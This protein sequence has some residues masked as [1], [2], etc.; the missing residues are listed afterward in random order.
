MFAA[1][2]LCVDGHEFGPVNGRWPWVMTL[3]VRVSVWPMLAWNMTLS[4]WLIS[5]L[6]T[7][8]A[9][10][11]I[12]LTD[13]KYLQC[14]VSSKLLQRRG[15]N[16]ARYYSNRPNL[17]ERHRGLCEHKH[18]VLSF[19]I[20]CTQRKGVG[21]KMNSMFSLGNKKVIPACQ[22]SESQ[23]VFATWQSGSF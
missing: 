8:K 2:S 23:A 1:Y 6:Q 22:K 9:I 11:S 20:L 12:F 10:I 3:L 16:W 21:L 15:T 7:C 4:D 14:E 17:L 5:I 18:V 13:A 19:L